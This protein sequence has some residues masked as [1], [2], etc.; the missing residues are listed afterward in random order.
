MGSNLLQ[1]L[2]KIF[3]VKE[4]NSLVTIMGSCPD[5]PSE[6]LSDYIQQSVVG[7]GLIT[8]IITYKCDHQVPP[9]VLRNL[10]EAVGGYYHCYSPETEV[11]PSANTLPSPPSLPACLQGCAHGIWARTDHAMY[12]LPPTPMLN[13]FTQV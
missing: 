7:R 5:Q 11:S 10:A 1:A 8:H 12:L 3:A 4:L 9:A 13:G 2:K 6:I